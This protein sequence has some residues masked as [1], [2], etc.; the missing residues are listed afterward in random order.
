[1]SKNVSDVDMSANNNDNYARYTCSKM[2]TR[3]IDNTYV[4]KT[5]Q[6]LHKREVH[7]TIKD[8]FTVD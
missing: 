2:Y 1:M 7:L 3:T 5:S 8:R 6:D 4:F